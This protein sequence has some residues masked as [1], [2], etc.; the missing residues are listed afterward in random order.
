MINKVICFLNAP[1]NITA[2]ATLRTL[3]N[4]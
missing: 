4:N 3:T 1:K 2:P